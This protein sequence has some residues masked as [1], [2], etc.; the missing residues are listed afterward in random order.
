ME[1]GVGPFAYLSGPR[2]FI[3][4]NSVHRAGFALNLSQ[5]ALNRRMQFFRSLPVPCV[6]TSRMGI[7]V[8]MV[9]TQAY[10]GR[11]YPPFDCRNIVGS[12]ARASLGAAECVCRRQ[13]LC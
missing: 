4:R 5:A 7:T 9:Q 12:S 10:Q 13:P 11:W 2:R 6:S 8:S 1:N 3:S